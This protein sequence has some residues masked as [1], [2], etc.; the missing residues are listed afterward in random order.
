MGNITFWTDPIILDGLKYAG[1][2]AGADAILGHHLD[3]LQGVEIYNDKPIAYSLGNFVFNQLKE[4]NKPS[5][6][7]ELDFKKMIGG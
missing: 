6:I 4:N 5:M 3:V 1:I 2:D 7:L